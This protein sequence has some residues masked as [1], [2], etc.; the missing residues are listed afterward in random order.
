MIVSIFNGNFETKANVNKTRMC[1]NSFG[2]CKPRRRTRS[3]R[4]LTSFTRLRPYCNI[5]EAQNGIEGLVAIE[6][7]TPDLV[8][9]DDMMPGEGVWVCRTRHLILVS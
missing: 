7:K 6:E 1:G 5:I 4:V 8:L 9:S 3:A 2:P